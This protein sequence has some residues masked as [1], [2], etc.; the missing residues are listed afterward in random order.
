MNIDGNRYEWNDRTLFQDVEEFEV[1]YGKYNSYDVALTF[2]DV[3]LRVTLAGKS[4]GVFLLQDVGLSHMANGVLGNIININ[5]CYQL[6]YTIIIV[7]IMFKTFLLFKKN[8][9]KPVT[10]FPQLISHTTKV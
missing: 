10:I 8:P 6:L 7:S 9:Y 5:I 2:Y 1:R 3:M 4:L